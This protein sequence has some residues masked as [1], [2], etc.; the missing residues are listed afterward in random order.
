MVWFILSDQY[1]EMGVF[2]YVSD[3]SCSQTIHGDGIIPPT[4]IELTPSLAPSYTRARFVPDRIF[5]G[6][7]GSEM[8]FKKC[9]GVLST[10][11]GT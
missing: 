10:S 6:I 9:L 11:R 4:P 5:L 7:E 1:C 2:L 3:L 8:I